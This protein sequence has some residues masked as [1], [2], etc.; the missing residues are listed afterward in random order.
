MATANVFEIIVLKTQSAGLA[1]QP[2]AATRRG[3]NCRKKKQQKMMRYKHRDSVGRFPFR[4]FFISM[5]NLVVGIDRTALY[6]RYFR[7]SRLSNFRD[8]KKNLKIYQ[9]EKC[10]QIHCRIIVRVP[11]DNDFF[12]S[13]CVIAVQNKV[14][15]IKTF[16]TF[17]FTYFTFPA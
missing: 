12:F 10:I 17:Y 8:I 1:G 11:C 14:Y 4:L 6:H 3:I 16:S 5:R 7:G 2:L 15:T 9:L 13:V